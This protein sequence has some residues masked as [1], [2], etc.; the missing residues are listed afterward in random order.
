MSGRSPHTWIWASIVL[1]AVGYAIDVVWHGLLNPG[2][3]PATVRDMARHLGTVHLP[4]YIG[5]A[6]VLVS[7][8]LALLRQ[9]RRRR[10]A[11]A[12][13]CLPSL[14]RCYLPA[15]RLGMLL[16]IFAW[17]PTMPP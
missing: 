6:S 9:L 3:E 7:T 1:Q 13:C 4:L 5:A 14:G 2:V 16:R 12:L 11:A 8:G 15:Q 10:M 17:T